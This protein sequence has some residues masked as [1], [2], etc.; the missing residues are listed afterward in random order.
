M[1][2]VLL[3][4]DSYSLKNTLVNAIIKLGHQAIVVNYWEFFSEL[5]NKIF[6]KTIGLPMRLK[7]SF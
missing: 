3:I 5:N 4:P 2:I 6:N 7:A 1:K